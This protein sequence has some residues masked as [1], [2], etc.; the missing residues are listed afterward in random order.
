MNLREHWDC[1]CGLF[2]SCKPQPLTLR[3]MPFTPPTTQP[4]PPTPM[5]QPPRNVIG[6]T[7]TCSTWETSPE[8]AWRFRCPIWSICMDDLAQI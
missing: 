8:T 7:N 4:T 6:N 2:Y 1:W 3:V 5:M